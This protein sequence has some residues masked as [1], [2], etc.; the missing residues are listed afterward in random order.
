MNAGTTGE[1]GQPPEQVRRLQDTERK[2]LGERGR[3]GKGW[4][5]DG[6][7]GFARG[8]TYGGGTFMAERPPSSLYLA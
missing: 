3:H 6:A 2:T 4:K 1:D 8:R 7:E 5:A